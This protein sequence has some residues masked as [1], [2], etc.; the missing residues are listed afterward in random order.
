VTFVLDTSV[1][2]AW[3]FE[4]EARTE[5]D[6]L[7]RSLGDE[8]A[9]VPALW[10][11]E[12]VS[13][14]L[15]AQRKGRMSEAQADRFLALLAQLPIEVE[16]IA[17]LT[18]VLSMGRRHVLSAYDAAYLELASRAG[19]GLATLDTRLADAAREVGVA[20]RL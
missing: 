3:C 16:T 2:M 8:P 13:V 10:Q 5:T 12:V 4:D 6:Q 11:W 14:L 7:L 18:G 17:T 19:L 1:T 20:L 9:T 15:V